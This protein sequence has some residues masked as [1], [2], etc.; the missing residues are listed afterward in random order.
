MF[1]DPPIAAALFPVIGGG[2]QIALWLV[3]GAHQMTYSLEVI[4][5]SMVR[6][7]AGGNTLEIEEGDVYQMQQC[8]YIII[9]DGGG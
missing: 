6:K 9:V 8:I 2:W 4:V 5:S 1:V 7:L 3:L